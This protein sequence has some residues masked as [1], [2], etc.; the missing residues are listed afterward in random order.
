MG[1]RK[2][3]KELYPGMGEDFYGPDNYSPIIESLGDAVA[4]RFDTDDYTGDSWVIYRNK[5]GWSFL[6]FGWGSCSGCDALQSC[7]TYE[8]IDALIGRLEQSIRTFQSA[9]EALIFFVS[10]DWGGDYSWAND[11]FYHFLVA[12]RRLLL[13]ELE[14]EEAK[15][16]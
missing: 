2:T 14:H 8:E 4:L 15:E 5:K 16:L 10:H 3:A 7:S 12:A 13:T 11:T 1:T 9:K 6:N